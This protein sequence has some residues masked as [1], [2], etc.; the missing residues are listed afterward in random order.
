MVRHRLVLGL[1]KNNRDRRVP[2]PASVADVLRQHMK[3]HPPLTVTLPWEDPAS[4]EQV[5]TDLILTTT[6]RKPS[7]RC[8]FDAKAWRPAVTAAGILPSRSTGMHALRHFYASALLD[9]GESIKALGS[10]LGH[11]DPGFTLRVYTHLRPASEERTRNAIDRPESGVQVDWSVAHQVAASIKAS[12]S[13]YVGPSMGVIIGSRLTPWRRPQPGHHQRLVHAIPPRGEWVG[14]L[15]QHDRIADA[16]NE[17]I[18]AGCQR[19]S[20]LVVRI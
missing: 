6:W 2:L 14:G 20:P 13:P 15:A 18:R 3:D 1:P 4:A 16:L 7:N 9:A 8:W 11:S 19:P 5:T 17:R 12:A 10:Y